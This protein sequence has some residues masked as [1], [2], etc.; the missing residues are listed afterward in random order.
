MEDSDVVRRI[1]TGCSLTAALEV[2]GERWSFLILR[3]A[4]NGLEH[5]EQFQSTLGIARN[6]LAN[7]LSRLVA[8]G[9]L[10][11]CPCTDDKR[12][13]EYLLTEKGAALLPALV[14]LRQWGAKWAACGPTSS[15]LVDA[16]DGLPVQEMSIFAADGRKLDMNE[17]RWIVLD[18]DEEVAA[19][20]PMAGR[21][22][23]AG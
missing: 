10:E 16:R 3:G 11:R 12:K 2:V 13:V 8:H 4:F 23:A 9:L 20:R 7:R 17:L 22:A 1:V 6:I 19:E 15:R 21:V 5:F 14:S 18:Q